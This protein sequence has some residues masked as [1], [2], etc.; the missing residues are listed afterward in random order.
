VR[1]PA[2]T[3]R[4]HLVGQAAARPTSTASRKR[5]WQAASPPACQVRWPA[6]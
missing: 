1:L 3:Q 4:V 6:S 2:R 5:C